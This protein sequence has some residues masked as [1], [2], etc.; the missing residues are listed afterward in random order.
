MSSFDAIL[1]LSFGG[2]EGPDDVIPFLRNVVRG[3]NVPEERLLSVARH[4]QRFGGV[5]PIN[6]QNRSLMKALEAELYEYNV[7]LPIYW[8]NRNWHPMLE[9]T[10]AKMSRHGVKRA[11]VFATSA[12]SSYSSCRQ[13]LEDIDRACASVGAKA[14]KI[15]KIKPFYNR[16]GFVQANTERLNEALSQLNAPINGEIHVAFSAHS[17]PL[18]M[19]KGCRYQEQLELVARMVANSAGISDWKLVFQ[20]RSG[21]P[22]VPWLEP[23]IN[24]HL[25]SLQETGTKHVVVAPVSCKERR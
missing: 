9:D 5:S 8:G 6:E 7:D 19:A 16:P 13:Y 21:P 3:K 24:D 4:Y 20:S 15:E 23:D 14:P 25:R 1:L 11:L 12:Y 18:S 2:P 17:I 22:N 10:V